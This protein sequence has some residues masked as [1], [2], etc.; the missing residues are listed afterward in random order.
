MQSVCRV[1]WTEGN[2][3]ARVHKLYGSAPFCVKYTQFGNS[4][5]CTLFHMICFRSALNTVVCRE[6]YV[7]CT[8]VS[9]MLDALQSRKW[10]LSAEA[11]TLVQ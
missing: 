11:S 4:A 5:K 10:T 2:R 1:H 7:R 8:Y 9:K 3:S 6:H